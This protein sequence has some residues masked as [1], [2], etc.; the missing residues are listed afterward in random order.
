MAK[1]GTKGP[2]ALL[3]WVLAPTGT[4]MCPL[5]VHTSRNP[6]PPTARANPHFSACV[7]VFL[8]GGSSLVLALSMPTARTSNFHSLFSILTL[9]SHSFHS[10]LHVFLSWLLNMLLICSPYSY[11]ICILIFICHI[12]LGT[13]FICILHLYSHF[14][15]LSGP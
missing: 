9:I 11:S 3:F 12:L 14:W 7:H 2:T 5:Y 6:D 4:K 15:C 10:F 13:L 8:L 1:T